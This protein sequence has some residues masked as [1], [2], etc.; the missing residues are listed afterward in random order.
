MTS[1][2]L[3]L[4]TVAA[5]LAV[6]LTSLLPAQAA[7]PVIAAPQV[8]SDQGVTDVQYRRPQE[9]RGWYNGHRGYRDRRPGYR[10]HNG[11][12]FPLAAFGAGALIGGAVAA[13]RDRGSNYGSRHYAWCEN[14]YRTY[15]AS[16]NTFVASGGVR[17]SC[18]SPFR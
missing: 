9:R 5:G 7:M 1:L 11:M 4:T 16:D 3:R 12:W 15:R 17:R 13:D 14:Q 6:T 8:S 2:R 10:Q 18:V